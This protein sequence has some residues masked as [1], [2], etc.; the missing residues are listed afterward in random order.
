LSPPEPDPKI[1]IVHDSQTEA[2]AKNL[3]Q[4][5]AGLLNRRPHALCYRRVA[6]DAATAGTPSTLEADSASVLV[7]VLSQLDTGIQTQRGAAADTTLAEA[8][9]PLDVSVLLTGPFTPKTSADSSSVWGGSA[10]QLEELLGRIAGKLGVSQTLDMLAFRA[11]VRQLTTVAKSSPG[12]QR[13]AKRRR[14]VLA[15]VLAGAVIVLAGGYLAGVHKLGFGRFE[16]EQ[17]SGGWTAQTQGNSGCIGAVQ[18]RE[19]AKHGAHSLELKLQLAPGSEHSRAGEAF[20]D[21]TKPRSPELGA[22][23]NMNSKLISAWVYTPADASGSPLAPN[24]YQL[25]VKDG[26]YKSHYG[27]WTNAEADSWSRVQLK[28]GV[29]EN[30]SRPQAGFS[31]DSVA[32]IGIK[33]ELAGQATEGFTGSV[34]LDS[35]DF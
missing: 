16:F 17:D 14:V 23:L 31:A 28:V 30:G 3:G 10:D 2:F 5:L 24:G 13:Y 33:L 34:Y 12:Y 4:L 27:A 29:A 6:P 9:P 18:T 20:V 25:F 7:R 22:P 15:S 11:R 8:L 1:V 26:S 32:V 19:H 21:L 35:V